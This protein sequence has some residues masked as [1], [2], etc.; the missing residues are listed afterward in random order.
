M[1]NV[2]EAGSH[3]ILVV[4]RQD[5]VWFVSTLDWC[6]SEDVTL[7]LSSQRLGGKCS[8]YLAKSQFTTSPTG[9]LYSTF[10]NSVAGLT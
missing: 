6:P 4:T 8:K 3:V 9:Q 5:A 10:A 2:D 7:S 1:L